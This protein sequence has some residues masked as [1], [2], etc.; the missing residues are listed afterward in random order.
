MRI[1]SI[2]RQ[3][4]LQADSPSSNKC[5]SCIFWPT[6]GEPPRLLLQPV[7]MITEAFPLVSCAA[8]R[9]GS[10]TSSSISTTDPPKWEVSICIYSALQ[11]ATSRP[12]IL[13]RQVGPAFSHGIRRHISIMIGFSGRNCQFKTL[14]AR[15]IVLPRHLELHRLGCCPTS[16][17]SQWYD[18][19][20]CG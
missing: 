19:K 1:H 15:D 5:L 2:D 20:T 6:S 12:W 11:T 9:S 17:W 10:F 16:S 13:F 4:K 18:Y 14:G 3:A 8:I 7:P